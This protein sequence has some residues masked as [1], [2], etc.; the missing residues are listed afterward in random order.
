MNLFTPNTSAILAT[1]SD[2]LNCN[3]SF[4]SYVKIF[5]TIKLGEKEIGVFPKFSRFPFI[6]ALKSL[7]LFELIAA[8]VLIEKF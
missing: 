2:P 5:P 7:F 1:F 6:E 4:V 8:F 3:F